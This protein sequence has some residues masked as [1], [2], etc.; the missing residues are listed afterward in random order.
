M[1]YELYDVLFDFDLFFLVGQNLSDYT[2]RVNDKLYDAQEVQ[3]KFDEDPDLTL[4][5]AVEGLDEYL[6]EEPV[7]DLEAEYIAN[8]LLGF[9][10]IVVSLS[11][12]SEIVNV[13][14][15]EVDGTE[16]PYE[17]EGSEMR[18]KTIGIVTKIEVFM[19]D[20]TKLI[21]IEK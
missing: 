21:A 5:E 9:T 11:D 18:I 15:I 19:K 7:D 10:G 13:D 1:T 2:V 3:N 14:K 8:S 12:D 4:E 20:G 16:K 6:P 17:V